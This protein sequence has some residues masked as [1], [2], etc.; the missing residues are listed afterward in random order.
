MCGEDEICPDGDACPQAK[1]QLC[2]RDV[3]AEYKSLRML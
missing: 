1:S 3:N 2:M